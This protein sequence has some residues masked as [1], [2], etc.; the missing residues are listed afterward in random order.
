MS[1]VAFDT[2]TTGF[3]WSEAL[4]RPTEP[5][6]V[7]WADDENPDGLHAHLGPAKASRRRNGAETIATARKII[8]GAD[9]LVGH[10]LPFDVHMMDEA[11]N[12]ALGVMNRPLLDTRVLAQITMPERR[13]QTEEEG[14]GYHLKD[15]SLLWDPTAKDAEKALEELAEKHGFSLKAKPG[16]AKY[17]EASYFKLWELE[18]E[19]VEFYGREDAR[20][21]LGT[22]R[23]LE[24]KLTDGTRNIWELEQKVMPVL[25]GA[26]AKGIRV[27]SEK[28]AP[29]RA[30]YASEHDR[31]KAELDA[32]LQA[33][34]DQ[35]DDTLAEALVQAG[36]PL[37]EVT[38]KTG[39][40]ATNKWALEKLVDQHPVIQTLFDYR[41]AGKF[42]STYLDH[43]I[44]REIIHP[45]FNQIGTWTGR[46]SAQQPNMQ[47]IPVRAGKQVRELFLP[48]EGMVFVGI[49]YEQIE[50]R[51][52]CYYLNKRKMVELMEAGHDPF[53]QLAADVFGGDPAEYRKG[54]PKEAQRTICKNTTYAV[55]YG[56]G[57]MKVCKMLGWKADSVYVASDWVVQHG[58]KEAGEPRS[59]A[60]EQLIKRLK[61][62]LV[63]YD[64]LAGPRGR[65]K[66]KVEATGAVDTIMGRHQWLGYEGAYKGLSGLI[67]GGAADIF[68]VGLIDAVEAVKPLGAYPLLF[69]H[70]EVLLECPIG[71]E[72]EV[73]RVASEALVGAYP[74]RPHLAVESHIAYNNWGETK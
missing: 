43:F 50:F 47:N 58:Y 64:I 62:A 41:Q 32:A 20:E 13:I 48:R 49:D 59:K 46:M 6:M 14:R 16:T 69:I 19:A 7:Q 24:N 51:L 11:T 67:Q 3:L 57:G 9:R 45:T 73:E 17:V 33:G 34:W 39:K 71:T 26:E 35:N 60:A 70:D 25:I 53:A 52:L 74:L 30:E 8:R 2:E 38:E 66:A 5:Y 40:L 1:D 42:V 4:G 15:L 31:L 28:A 36:V 18:P 21:T 10:N 54:A 44:G 56:A 12:W 27:D 63:G 68:K 23:Y 29:L 37:T 61:A 55:I 65:I 22:L 72:K